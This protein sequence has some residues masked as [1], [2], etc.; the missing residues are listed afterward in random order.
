MGVFKD[1]KSPYLQY[2]FTVKG[3]RY[4]GSTGLNSRSDAKEWV[5]NE[6]RKIILGIEVEKTLTVGQGFAKYEL[7]HLQ[8]KPSYKSIIPKINHVMEFLG[9]N[10][11]LHSVGQNDLE[12]YIAHCRTETFRKMV[13]SP[14][15]GKM[16]PI[17]AGEHAKPRKVSV[18]TI[19]RRLAAF[20]AMHKKAK[21]SWKVK[22]QEIDFESLFLKETTVINNTL[23][24]SSP[25]ILWDAAK[26][27]I[28]HFIMITLCTGWRSTPVLRMNGK[29]QIVLD[30]P[31]PFVWT[32]G[33]GG[34]HIETP[35]TDV[36]MQY[37]IAN[38]LQHMDLICDFWG[39][40][41]PVA[42]IKTTWKTLFK[43]TGIKYIR[44]HDLR[45]T[46][47]T[48]LYH[49]T[50]DQR[51]VQEALVHSDI[52]TSIRYTHTNLDMLREQMNKLPV[53][54]NQVAAAK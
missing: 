52:T 45:H 7:E 2:S 43:N 35:I 9:K 42:S 13:Y 1:K 28:R 39:T 38:G 6:R 51:A 5:A 25:Q 32:I 48:W 3:V 29:K 53:K 8:F 20:Q 15:K 36:F 27:H 37:I 22:V 46:F 12:R 31:V 14:K 34:K 10:T 19:N 23:A 11:C 17:K 24:V 41:E 33:K 47:G 4:R 18:A 44:P 49:Y 26:P 30:A 54:I 40:G 50:K 21:K 16:I